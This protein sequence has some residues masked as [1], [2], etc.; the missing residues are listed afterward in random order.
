VRD[1]DLRYRHLLLWC[2]GCDGMHAINFVREGDVAPPITWDFDGNVESP[3][4]TPSLLVTMR[5][6]GDGPD[7]YER[8]CHSYITGGQWVFLT[9]SDHAL[10][11]QTVPLPPLPDWVAREGD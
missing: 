3:T 11:G 9:D 5:I 8:K 7:A 6:G 10:A 1:G 2:P 4:V